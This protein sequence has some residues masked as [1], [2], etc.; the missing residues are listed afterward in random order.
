MSKELIKKHLSIQKNGFIYKK[1]QTKK[2]A[3][4]G[5]SSFSHLSSK[6]AKQKVKLILNYK[7]MSTLLNYYGKINIQISN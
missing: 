4:D 3:Y 7:F 2:L 1:N 5:S 6:A